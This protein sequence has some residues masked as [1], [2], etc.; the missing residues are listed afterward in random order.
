MKTKAA[1]VPKKETAAKK[2]KRGKATVIE[3]SS[4][5]CDSDTAASKKP[6]A[7]KK[8]KVSKVRHLLLNLSIRS[9]K[10]PLHVETFS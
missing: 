4:D 2:G 3:S 8:A 1:A 6:T 9:L 10:P 7:V 5:E